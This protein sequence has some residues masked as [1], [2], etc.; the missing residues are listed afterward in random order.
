MSWNL[1]EIKNANKTDNEEKECSVDIVVE[2]LSK[3]YPNT[4]RTLLQKLVTD[5]YINYIKQKKKDLD[6]I[7]SQYKELNPSIINEALNLLK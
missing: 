5:I 1:K 3:R 2:I 4:D 7:I 6:T